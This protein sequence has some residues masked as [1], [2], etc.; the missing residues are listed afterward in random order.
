[1]GLLGGL[2]RALAHRRRSVNSSSLEDLEVGL[3]LP[4]MVDSQGQQGHL[5]AFFKFNTILLIPYYVQYSV[6]DRKM[7]KT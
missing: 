3:N 6:G 2:S 7:I 5:I 1:M 4:S